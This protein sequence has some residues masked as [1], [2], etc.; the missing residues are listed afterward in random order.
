VKLQKMNES[1]DSNPEKWFLRKMFLPSLAISNFALGSMGVLTG[2]LLIDIASTFNVPVGVMGQSNTA[3]YFVAV[4]VALF[5]GALSVRFRPRL[6]LMIGM[7]G[8]LFSSL[9][10]FFATDFGMMLVS[11][12]LSGV[13]TAMVF[14]MTITL[15]GKHISAEKKTSAIGWIV[16]AT[17]LS[18]LAGA[19]LIGLLASSMNWRFVILLFVLPVTLAS[20]LLALISVPSSASDIPTPPNETHLASLRNVFSDKSTIACLSGNL[21]HTTAF[22]AIAFY[23]VSFFRQRF[24]IT[25][26]FGAAII[27]GA[28]ACYTL[29]SLISGYLA[30]KLG[31]KSLVIVAYLL[32]GIITVSVFSVLNLWCSL[33][34]DF[35]GALCAG[36]ASPAASSLT[37]EQTQRFQ[38]TVISVN[39]AA[40]SLGNA[41]GAALGGSLLVLSGYDILGIALG[42]I[43][44]F[45]ALIYYVL[46]VDPSFQKLNQQQKSVSVALICVGNTNKLSQPVDKIERAPL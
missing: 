10:C 6:L 7:L 38:G 8:F 20:L 44:I 19:P 39:S 3:S 36:I 18:F 5:T 1:S 15:I 41:F 33:V 13:G 29:G 43:G 27:F 31:R 22:M 23:A 42:T 35:S 26:D 46:A 34:L 14:P 30:R 40:L 24:Q 37:L 21:L 16:A 4:V 12:S 28:A 45:A 9:G 2:L 11:Y 17:S 25:T 32:T